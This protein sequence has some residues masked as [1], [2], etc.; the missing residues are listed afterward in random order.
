MSKTTISFKCNSSIA[1]LMLAFYDILTE[2]DPD[3]TIIGS[4]YFEWII[5]ELG[6]RSAKYGENIKITKGDN[7]SKGT[8]ALIKAYF[9]DDV[10]REIEP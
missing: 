2:N 6:E 5:D 7:L 4:D 3:D 8:R 1:T 10:L 9:G